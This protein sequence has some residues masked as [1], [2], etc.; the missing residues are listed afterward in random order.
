M[1]RAEGLSL[2]RGKETVFEWEGISGTISGAYNVEE[3]ET[4][5][6]GMDQGSLSLRRGFERAIWKDKNQGNLL[7]PEGNTRGVE[8]AEVRFTRE[9][10]IEGKGGVREW[11][12]AYNTNAR[13]HGMPTYALANRFQLLAWRLATTHDIAPKRGIMIAGS[14]SDVSG[15]KPATMYFVQT[16]DG[17]ELSAAWDHSSMWNLGAP[18]LLVRTT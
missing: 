4:F 15:G 14:S 2:E 17:P 12:E 5:A 6:K 11:L 9:M 18:F 7:R 8:L 10:R 3:P 1:S 13:R 16:L